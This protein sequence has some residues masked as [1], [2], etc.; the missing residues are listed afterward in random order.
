MKAEVLTAMQKKASSKKD[1][2]YRLRGVPY[3]VVRGR[4]AFYVDFKTVYSVHGYFVTSRGSFDFE[5]E[6]I[7]WMKKCE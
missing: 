2:V 5:S 7:K 1:G 4:V 3:R 6:A